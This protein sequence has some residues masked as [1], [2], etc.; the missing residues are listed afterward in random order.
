MAPGGY[1]WWY[2]DAL[3]DCG[4]HAL[5]VIAFVGSVFSPYYAWRGRRDPED[6]VAINVCLY[7][8]GSNRWTMT[9]RGRAALERN[10]RMLRIGPSSLSWGDEGL[11]IEID[12][13]SPPWPPRQWLPERLR[14]E[15]RIDPGPVFGETV[16]LDADGRHYWRPVAPLARISVDM[17]ESASRRWN[18]AAYLDTNW[19]SESLEAG[20][21]RWDWARGLLPD[22]S[23]VIV[24]APETVRGETAP[25]GVRLDAGGGIERFEPPR[26]GSLGRGF[27]G[28]SRYMACEAGVAPKL[29][30]TLEDSP[31]YVRSLVETRLLGRDVTMMHES[32]SGSRFASPLVRAMLPFRMPR[33]SGA[34]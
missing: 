14:G 9:E 32:F 20:F 16:S 6:H 19:G 8:R 26:P 15:I 17:G 27:W 7:S 25:M 23:A 31:F 29:V 18:G 10:S 4:K 11:L 12:E 22:G 2:V 30:R 28:V 34:V 1:R 13:I 21:H 24:Y 3:S 5:T 33:R